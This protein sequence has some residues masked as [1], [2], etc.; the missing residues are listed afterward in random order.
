MLR[1]KNVSAQ[2][3]MLTEYVKAVDHVNFEVRKNEIF[4][5][6]G[7]SGCGKS[8][9]LKVMYDL[10][11]YPLEILEGSVEIHSTDKNGNPLV[12]KNGDIHKSWWKIISYVP[13]GAMHVMNPVTRIKSQFFD[14]ISKYHDKKNKKELEAE[15]AA[16]LKEL[17]LSPEVLNAYPHQLS[18]GMRQRVLI[19]LATFLHP[20]IVLADEPTTALDVI[21]QRGILTMLS[22]VQ[23]KMGN[24]MVIVSHDMGVHYQITNRMG[25][26]YAGQMIEV[27]PTEQ[28]F[29]NPQHPYTKMLINALPKVGDNSQKEGIPGTPP[30]LKQ[31]PAGCR[32]AARCPVAMDLC[33][34]R[35]PARY[36]VG[37]D[38]FA[39]CHLLS[40]MDIAAEVERH[41]A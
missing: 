32:F 28:I 20:E 9:L 2:Y 29:T 41:G 27:G 12:Y 34:T 23:K 22:R 11:N 1:L 14:A 36:E 17:E 15:I 6:A 24:S 40:D 18:G 19:A 38:H 5:I 7:E 37:A 35:E 4:G 39:S 25:I 3:N 33:R 30:S 10:I 26:M 21:V 8:T 16:Y 31:P 13:Q